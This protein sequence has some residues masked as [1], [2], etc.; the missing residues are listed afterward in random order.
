MVRHGAQ[1]LPLD[2]EAG[3]LFRDLRLTPLLRTLLSRSSGLVGAVAGSI[4]FVDGSAGSYTKMAEIGAPCRLGQRF[5]IDEGMTGQVHRQRRPVALS[6]Y[7]DVRHGHLRVDSAVAAGSVVAVPIWWRG[8]VLG[9]NVVFAGETR[10]FAAGDIDALEMLTQLAA[11]A[12]VQSASSDPMLSRLLQE[13]SA[14]AASAG[15]STVVTEIRPRPV[16]A[17][18]AELAV[19]L[20]AL[21]EH[22]VAH[23]ATPAVLHVALVHQPAGLRLLV[24]VE[25]GCA[26]TLEL[27]DGGRLLPWQELLSRTGGEVHAQDVPGWGT[28]LQAVLPYRNPSPGAPTASAP[29]PAPAAAPVPRAAPFA[30]GHRDTAVGASPEGAISSPPRLTARERQVLELLGKGLTDRAIARTLVLSP[31]TVEK[32]VGALIR[33]TGAASRTGAVL[34]AIDGGW[35]PP[36]RSRQGFE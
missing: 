19:G 28:L 10:H 7:R 6:S 31:R 26:G 17:S 15:V 23:G 12:I 14:T 13:R 18:V 16:P 5:P 34:A 20:V 36:T 2:V 30:P 9:V 27:L 1:L 11:P 32:Y 33:K 29:A 22:A 21:A 3:E 24:H 25:Q 35:V 8:D 4:S